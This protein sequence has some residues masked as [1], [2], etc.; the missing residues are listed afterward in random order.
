MKI[1]AMF[2]LNGHSVSSEKY[3]AMKIE[4]RVEKPS[5]SL[6]SIFR[7]LPGLSESSLK[8]VWKPNEYKISAYYCKYKP[9]K[10]V[11]NAYSEDIEISKSG[12][13][14]I[15]PDIFA[16]GDRLLFS[17]KITN[18]FKYF[19]SSVELLDIPSSYGDYYLLDFLNSI[20]AFDYEKS[21]FYWFYEEM[22][23]T[24]GI[25]K[26][27]FEL[28][29]VYKFSFI[30]EIVQKQ[31]IFIL[32][33]AVPQACCFITD[34][35]KKIIEE[36]NIHLNGEIQLVWDSENPNYRDERFKNPE[37]WESLKEQYLEFR[38]QN[39]KPGY[40]NPNPT[41]QKE[42]SPTPELIQRN[43]DHAWHKISDDLNL[44]PE[45]ILEPMLVIARIAAWA[46]SAHPGLI[47]E[48]SKRKAAEKIGALWGDQLRRAHDWIWET[49]ESEFV[50]VPPERDFEFN[51]TEFMLEILQNRADIG[52]VSALF[53]SLL[54][55]AFRA[56]FGR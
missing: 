44:N 19:L 30:E 42:K 46:N 26:R 5:I 37:T 29:D 9:H 18:I 48:R 14:L 31:P 24:T 38:T 50:I 15:V 23:L 7:R 28:G 33:R 12:M 16:Y 11:E 4:A 51:T 20:D 43:T 27:I 47:P 55:P 56:T 1:Y 52:Q 49:R 3:A 25:E 54:L 21:C 32:P 17:K 35:V 45:P 2:G 10:G 22:G 34:E 40:G 13:S 39:P 8:E 36:H 41:I 6:G 53:N